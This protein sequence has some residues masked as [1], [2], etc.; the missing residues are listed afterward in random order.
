MVRVQVESAHQQAGN[1]SRALGPGRADVRYLFSGH[2]VNRRLQGH[3]GERVPAREGFPEDEVETPEV[4]CRGWRGARER[5]GRHV[6]GRAHD[7]PGERQAELLVS[8]RRKA[9][10][11]CRHLEMGFRVQA[12]EAEVEQLR[13]TSPGK[14]DI[15]GLYVPVQE[16]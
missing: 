7:L 6:E 10:V 14:P 9:R 13:D 16:A 3:P 11:Q 12:G 1:L 5:L 15:A 8:D 4:M 2:P